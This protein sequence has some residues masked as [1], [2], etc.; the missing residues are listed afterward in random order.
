[1]S[2][3]NCN[4]LFMFPLVVVVEKLQL[5]R[6]LVIR[7]ITIASPSS[8]TSLKLN[9]YTIKQKLEKNSNHLEDW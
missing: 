3:K 4:I 9:I 6:I 1:M 7:P 5:Q 2:F 8:R